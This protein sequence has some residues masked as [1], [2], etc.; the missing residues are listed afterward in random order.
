V[1]LGGR[2]RAGSLSVGLAELRPGDTLAG[3]IERAD[4]ALVEARRDPGQ[5]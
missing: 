4:Q 5:P 2:D 3:L 1:V